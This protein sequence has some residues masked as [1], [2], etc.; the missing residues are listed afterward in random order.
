MHDKEFVG[1]CESLG[2]HPL[3]VVGCHVQVADGAFAKLMG[4]LGIPRPTDIPLDAITEWTKSGGIKRDWFNPGK[5]RGRSS[6]TK[7]TCGCGEHVRVGKK[8]WPGAVCKACGTEY[9]KDDGLTHTLYNID[10]TLPESKQPITR[11]DL[12]GDRVCAT[13]SPTTRVG[14]M[15]NG[16]VFFDFTSNVESCPIRADILYDAEEQRANEREAFPPFE[17][18]EPD[19]PYSLGDGY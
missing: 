15:N 13:F 1:K 6:L 9:V 14:I 4:E 3:P 7:Y 12:C 18:E 17:D 5:E 11:C 16:R 10:D 19:N 8:D 2:L